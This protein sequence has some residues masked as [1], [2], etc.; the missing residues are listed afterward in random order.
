M[1]NALGISSAAGVRSVQVRN[2]LIPRFETVSTPPYETTHFSLENDFAITLLSIPSRGTLYLA[3][4]SIIEATDLPLYIGR[5]ALQYRPPDGLVSNQS[6][7]I[8]AALT[9][10][11]TDEHFNLSSYAPSTLVCSSR[12]IHHAFP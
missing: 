1:K 4:S 7:P 3:N 5:N 8:V 9:Y 6:H 11:Y 2:W 10:R 12:T